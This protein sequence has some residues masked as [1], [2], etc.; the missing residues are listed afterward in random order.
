MWNCPNTWKRNSIMATYDPSAHLT[1]YVVCLRFPNLSMSA[2]PDRYSL[3][4]ELNLHH[5][6]S[7]NLSLVFH[8][9]F[10]FGKCYHHKLWLILQWSYCVSWLV[11]QLILSLEIRGRCC[12]CAWSSPY[13]LN[14]RE[15]CAFRQSQFIASM[16]WKSC[17]SDR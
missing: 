4:L 11:S 14:V 16:N 15:D 17:S 9:P 8:R 7:E 1:F 10:F 6:S 12:G 13:L 3:G 5:W 2:G